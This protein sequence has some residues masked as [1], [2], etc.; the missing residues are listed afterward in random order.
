MKESGTVFYGARATGLQHG[1]CSTGSISCFMPAGLLMA[2]YA[3]LRNTVI[4]KKAQIILKP[5]ER[6]DVPI[7]P[8]QLF[9]T[10]STN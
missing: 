2:C 3:V 6:H 1:A 7:Q 10:H 8:T 9:A 5:A 4:K